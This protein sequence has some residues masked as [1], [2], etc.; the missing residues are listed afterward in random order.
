MEQS[1]GNTGTRD[2]T[3]DLVS[4]MY[5]ALQGAETIEMYVDDADQDNEE[6]AEFFSETKDD[7]QRIADRAKELFFMEVSDMEMDDED[8][9]ADSAAG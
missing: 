4:I 3:F 6:L 7:Y 2:V 9:M 8:E 5:H 1:K